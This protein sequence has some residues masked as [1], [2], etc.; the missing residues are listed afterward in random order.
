MIENLS[1]KIT[2]KIVL[3]NEYTDEDVEKIQY[4]LEAIIGE[5]SKMTFLIVF[6][7]SLGRLKYFIFSSII[8]ISIRI[9]SGGVHGK[10]N[11]EC[12]I[13]SL[14]I[15]TFPCIIVIDIINWNIVIFKVLA[16][17]SILIIAF[18]SP[19]PSVNRPIISRKRKLKF[20]IL[21]TFFCIAWII[22]LFNFS[23][24][25]NLF[26]CGISIIILQAAQLLLAQ[27]ISYIRISM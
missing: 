25:S 11:L 3:D 16:V 26:K 1:R 6:F 14:I 24:G 21:A 12:L 10:N 18:F 19:I 20:K 8:L 5:V 9:Y 22:I 17:F 27:L 23:L 2:D 4:S 15:F 13:Y 7:L